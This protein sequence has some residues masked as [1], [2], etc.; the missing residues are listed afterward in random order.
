MF[1]EI[2]NLKYTTMDGVWNRKTIIQKKIVKRK[3]KRKRKRVRG[4]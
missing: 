4:R 1:G 2:K 3:R